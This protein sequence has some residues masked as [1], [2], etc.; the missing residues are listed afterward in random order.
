MAGCLLC[1]RY[2][3]GVH[4]E[5]LRALRETVGG[6][7]PEWTRTQRARYVATLLHSFYLRGLST[8]RVLLRMSDRNEYT[9]LDRKTL[10]EVVSLLE[11]PD[12]IVQTA[13]EKL[14]PLI[15][16]REPKLFKRS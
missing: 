12:A 8:E 9:Y 5:L 4:A 6:L 2:C 11:K 10:E 3:E 15:P 16:L 13:A 14:L 7:R 1:G